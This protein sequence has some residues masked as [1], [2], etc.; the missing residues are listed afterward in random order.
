MTIENL[1]V[2]TN[3]FKKSPARKKDGLHQIKIRVF[4]GKLE[5]GKF[6]NQKT[7]EIKVLDDAESGL[8]M[9]ASDFDNIDKNKPQQYHILKAELL[10]KDSVKQMVSSNIELT[11][12]NLF[13]FI[14][15]SSKAAKPQEFKTKEKEIWNEEVK[16]FFRYPIP[17]SVWEEFL[18][19]SKTDERE[20]ITEEDVSD[21]ADGIL[22][23]HARSMELKRIDSMDFHDRYKNGYFNKENIFEVF[24]FCWTKN[25]KNGR[26]YVKEGYKS[27]IFHLNDFRF[28][29]KPSERIADFND[30]WIDQF[31]QFKV[32]YGKPKLHIK[33]YDPFSITKYSK[34][35]ET[36]ERQPYQEN[37]FIAIIKRF[38]YCI[39]LLH[40]FDLLPYSK[41]T[42]L[43]KAVDYLP[44]GSGKEKFTRKT[45]YLTVPEFDRLAETD[46]KE[47]KLNLARDM[48][49]IAV[50]GGGFRT[51]ELYEYVFYVEDNRLHFYRSKTDKISINPVFEQLEDVL[52]RHNGIPEFLPV[53]EYRE[54]LK[55]IAN[56]LEFKRKIS[57]P[58]TE[59]GSE[60]NVKV[61][62]LKDIFNSYFAR[63]TCVRILNFLGLSEEEIIE[64]TGQATK[65]TLRYYKDNMTIEDK[66]RLI[67]E[68]LAALRKRN[69]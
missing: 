4:I 31:F 40:K 42:E 12:K 45:H 36:A 6:R 60:R 38:K 66:E 15:R 17:E 51:Q 64:F 24:G 59:I 62:I 29:A 65:E 28:N 41:D 48:F 18:F 69:S 22:F 34:R 35:F 25:P 39:K 9:R 7:L 23:D 68:K 19:E 13:D 8:M 55:K 58:D 3:S 20:V 32:E 56:V 54:S 1:E 27:V 37:T 50:L 49:I 5:F 33:N 43:I 57:C 16:K 61:E 14:N 63:K 53:D 67:R 46:F 11:S 2:R 44:S 26:P 10:A 47:E 52:E 30:D 21:I